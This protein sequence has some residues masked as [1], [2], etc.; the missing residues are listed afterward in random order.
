M[1]LFFTRHRRSHLTSGRA[2]AKAVL[3]PRCV[4][5]VIKGE[6]AGEEGGGLGR[7]YGGWRETAQV[8][9]GVG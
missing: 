6:G 8:G 9:G 7:S 3:G 4:E 1:F 2:D 5:G